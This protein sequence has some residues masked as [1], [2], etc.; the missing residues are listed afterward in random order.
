MLHYLSAAH[1]LDSHPKG[2]GVIR[3]ALRGTLEVSNALQLLK[4]HA[5]VAAPRARPD[6]PAGLMPFPW[7]GDLLLFLDDGKGPYCV[8]LTIKHKR[9]D[10]DNPPPGAFRRRQSA[11]EK[12]QARHRVES[13]YYLD[14]D[15]PTVR[16]TLKDFDMQLPLN[17]AQILLWSKRKN[18]F[19]EKKTREIV[20]CFKGAIG[21]NIPAMSIVHDLAR[22]NDCK[23]SKI[24]IVL[25]QAL[26]SRQI[27]IDL[28]QP[29]LIDK[30]LLPEKR[31]PF[32]VYGHWFV[33][34]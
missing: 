8:N 27:R 34:G 6:T 22:V 9:E 1:P 20:N 26:W 4:Y 16:L 25:H 12:A 7:V 17:L 2:A 31:D 24:K 3:P 13:L 14:A 10:F 19:S 15:I 23:I 32:A 28:F 21:T 5:M 11:A 18:S 29:F 33:R 30:P